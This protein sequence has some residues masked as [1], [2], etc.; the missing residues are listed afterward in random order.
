MTPE[1][2]AAI[3]YLLRKH[4][5]D[6]PSGYKD[7]GGR[8]YPEDSEKA[9]CCNSIRNP[10][11]AWPWTLFKHC[12]SLHHI[13]TMYG[14]E[15]NKVQ[16]LLRKKNLPLLLGLNTTVDTIIEGILNVEL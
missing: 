9:R 11:R 1:Q 13:V 2:S 10:S 14:A 8:W 4:K 16:E 12:F 3:T 5:K 7:N 15:R 6:Y